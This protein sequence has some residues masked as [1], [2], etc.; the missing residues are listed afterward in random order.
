MF[1]QGG[2]GIPVVIDVEISQETDMTAILEAGS[3]FGF[4]RHVDI[5][6]DID[7]RRIGPGSANI[8]GFGCRY[9]DSLIRFV[10]RR[11][12][13][14]KKFMRCFTILVPEA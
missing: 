2:G 6:Y 11:F 13:Q 5:R 12:F 14:I 4:D 8:L 1:S 3:A 7:R 9:D 10:I